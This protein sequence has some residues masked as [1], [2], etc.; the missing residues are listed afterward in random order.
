PSHVVMEL[1]HRPLFVV[2][3]TPVA[4][5]DLVT[6]IA[7]LIIARI[8]GGLLVRSIDR[9][10]NQRG[11]DASVTF[12]VSKIVRWVAV[13]V[14]ALI[15]LGTIGMNLSA[16]VAMFAV[17]LVGI[18]FG[19][20]K[21]AENFISGLILLIERP[22]RIG[23]FVS[24]DGCKGT[25]ADIRLRATRIATRDGVTYVI[26]N[27]ELIG[28]TVTNYTTPST[29][30]RV[31]IT[32]GVA[33]GTDLALARDVLL[34][35]ARAEPLVLPEPAPEVRHHGFGDSAINLALVVWI[36]NA[37]DDDELSSAVRFAIERAFAERG[38]SIPFPQREIN[39][40]GLPARIDE[41]RVEGRPH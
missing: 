16:V 13:I 24:V 19:L 26:P 8:V 33:Y 6:A 20:Q 32:V 21:M 36:Q 40:R 25:V 11:V 41:K 31:W 28:K 23:D 4:V 5:I 14:G 34:E 12:A 3:G 39:I 27:S 22:V 10:M 9:V 29:R 1:L 30:L 35:V 18:G 17:L 15:A 37:D 2:S 7:V 38:I